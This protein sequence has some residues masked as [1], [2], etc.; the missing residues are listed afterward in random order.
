MEGCAEPH[1]GLRAR[2]SSATQNGLEAAGGQKVPGW[3]GGAWARCPCAAR[4]GR[5]P[6]PASSSS[7]SSLWSMSMVRRARCRRGGW[8]LNPAPR[9]RVGIE[10]PL[11]VRIASRG[12]T[13]FG[14]CDYGRGCG[15]RSE[16]VPAARGQRR[17]SARAA[18]C[19]IGFRQ[20]SSRLPAGAHM[21]A[22]QPGTGGGGLMAPCP[23]G[24]AVL[25]RCCQRRS[26]GRAMPTSRD[27]DWINQA[28]H[29]LIRWTG[30]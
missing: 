27:A 5:R 8:D 2:F 16:A 17:S 7:S 15:S 21:P 23:V 24:G 22:R 29:R 4:A 19:F 11:A 25:E 28:P 18:R 14:A 30:N 13:T 3:S 26:G 9:S 1:L 12:L 20:R 10:K 6:S